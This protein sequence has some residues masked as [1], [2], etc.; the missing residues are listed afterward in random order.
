MHPT[1]KLLVPVPANALATSGGVLV[2]SAVGVRLMAE[3]DASP[4]AEGSCCMLGVP[5]AATQISE[6]ALR[7]HLPITWA[8]SDEGG[9]VHLLQLSGRGHLAARQVQ[10]P[11]PLSV[12][13]T[14]AFLP[15]WACPPDA[16][17]APSAGP[18]LDPT[19]S[20]KACCFL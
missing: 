20:L 2:I 11:V 19:H 3:Q 18:S 17:P 8:V 6:G 13:G 15:A 4:L 5:V 7:A 16:A 1:T 9:G 14:L 12:A 10:C